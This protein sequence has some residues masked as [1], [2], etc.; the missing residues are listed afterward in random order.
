MHPEI[1]EK[2]S[3]YLDDELTAA[4]RQAVEAHLQECEEC[5]ATLA[6]L[7]RIASA[8][9]AL[10]E[11]APSTDLWPGIAARI[12][13]GPRAA[14]PPARRRFAFTVPQLAA[15]SLL[16]V[17]LSGWLAVRMLSPAPP[18]DTASATGGS[19]PRDGS[20]SGSLTPVA[21]DEQQ[22]DTAIRELQEAIDRGRSRLDPETVAAVERNLR[23]IDQAV[24]D[25]RRAL[26]AD[27]SSGYL[28]GY[29]VQTRQRKLD[30]LR[31]VAVLTQADA[32]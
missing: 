13:A 3:D 14:A 29:M 21:F 5:A 2:L 4:E 22:Y 32:R 19:Q 18:R 28:S 11:T 9:G 23:L 24:D 17:A 26:A 25:A 6:D 20:G 16:L 10:R 30:L 8:A 12:A 27:P 15:A 1:A 7:G 31:Q